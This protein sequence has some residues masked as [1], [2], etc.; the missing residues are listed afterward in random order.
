MALQS[1]G[2]GG[3]ENPGQNSADLAHLS[4]LQGPATH[5]HVSFCLLQDIDCQCTGWVGPPLVLAP[6]WGSASS[7]EPV[8]ALSPVGPSPDLFSFK[9]L[10]CPAMFLS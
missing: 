6:T 8:Y 7:L 5:L 3:E 10:P 1:R 9:N 4:R 2:R